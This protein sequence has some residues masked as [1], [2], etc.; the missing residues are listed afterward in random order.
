MRKLSNPEKQLHYPYLLNIL[1]YEA[2]FH[3][4]IYLKC[5]VVNIR[6]ENVQEAK[7]Q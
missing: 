7:F 2:A 6:G 5:E 4:V 1:H 3:N